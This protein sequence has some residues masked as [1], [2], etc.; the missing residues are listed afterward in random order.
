MRRGRALEGSVVA[1]TAEEL[2]F[3]HDWKGVVATPLAD[4]PKGARPPIRD[5]PAKELQ[6][7]PLQ[8]HSFCQ[9]FSVFPPVA[10]WL[11]RRSSPPAHAQ[12]HLP[13]PPV[14]TSVD[15][16]FNFSVPLDTRRSAFSKS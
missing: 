3:T 15:E 10:R 8:V 12:R 14:A 5:K 11:L 16:E 4:R 6:A 13:I 7:S 9:T 2:C 1:A